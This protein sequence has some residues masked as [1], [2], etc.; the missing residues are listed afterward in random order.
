MAK[1]GQTLDRYGSI[2]GSYASPVGT[3]FSMR[4]LSPSTSPADYFKFEVI[5]PFPM[6][7]STIAPAFGQMGLG[8]QYQTPIGINYLKEFG[9]I[10]ILP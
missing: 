6:R 4:A 1:E 7:T 3:P 8:I 10:K 2:Y 9:Y 5:K